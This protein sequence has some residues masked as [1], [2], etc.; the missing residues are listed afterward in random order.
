MS[1]RRVKSRAQCGLLETDGGP[2]ERGLDP[3]RAPV[4]IG[5][6]EA[7]RGPLAGPVTVAAVVLP[8]ALIP[9][10]P[11]GIDDSKRLTEELRERLAPQIAG[12]LVHCIVHEGVD[13]IDRLNIRGATLGGMATA[14]RRVLE[15]AGCAPDTRVLVD[16]RD[17][18]PGIAG[19]QTPLVGGDGRSLAIAAASILAKTARDAWMREAAQRYPAYGFERHKG[20]GTRAHREALTLH[21]PCP[22]HRRSFTW[23]PIEGVGGLK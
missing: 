16:G 9:K 12:L 15:D 8:L 21:G 2:F 6:D 1:P 19:P 7:G 14:V 13:E 10:L 22:L 11:E 5:V 3:S 17:R 23:R 18:I 20:Y 4:V